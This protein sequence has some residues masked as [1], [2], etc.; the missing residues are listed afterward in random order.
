[1][2]TRFIFPLDIISVICY[3]LTSALLFYRRRLFTRFIF[4]LDIISVICLSAYICAPFLSRMLT[5]STDET[6]VCLIRQIL[7]ASSIHQLT[8][9][10]FIF[11]LDIISFI[12]FIS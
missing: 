6:D 10:I 1:L 5:D 7:S 2:F 8:S 3:Q 4:P 12:P 11:P 9:A